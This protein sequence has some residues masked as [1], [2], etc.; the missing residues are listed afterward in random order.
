MTVNETS[1]EYDVLPGMPILSVA[2]PEALTAH[3]LTRRRA[4]GS[5]P[6]LLQL[7]RS[8]D[9]DLEVCPSDHDAVSPRAMY[10]TLI[11]DDR[12]YQD[13]AYVDGV[14]LNSTEYSRIA[15]NVPA[16][17]RQVG[18]RIMR[19]RSLSSPAAQ[20][21]TAHAGIGH[22]LD[23]YVEKQT[24]VSVSLEKEIERLRAVERLASR[25]GFALTTGHDLLMK[26]ADVWEF[27]FMNLVRTAGDQQ[28]WSPDDRRR[29][30]TALARALS[31]GPQRQRI[32]GWQSYTSLAGNYAM[33]K[34]LLFDGR[35]RAIKQLM[36][37]RHAATS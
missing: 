24:K 9:L 36:K 23:G 33:T 28:Q 4:F 20:A 1:P 6:N 14:L 8:M 25:P 3:D 11:R 16:I 21:E 34:K 5:V 29:A 26:V 15:R 12:N 27:S 13:G 32:A 17:G 18:E 2:A 10:A 35:T 7:T 37:K 19:A 31:T 30:E 22:T